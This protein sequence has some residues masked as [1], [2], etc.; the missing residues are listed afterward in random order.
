MDWLKHFD[1]SK[2]KSFKA[3]YNKLLKK[4]KKI[5]ERVGS[6]MNIT[7][8]SEPVYDDNDK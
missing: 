5:W 6:L 4:Y 8:D 7:F 2:T 3:S 1:S